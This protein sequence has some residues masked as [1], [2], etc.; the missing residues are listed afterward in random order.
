MIIHRI[1]HLEDNIDLFDDLMD[2]INL[3][4]EWLHVNE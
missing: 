2:N 1:E 4:F 3:W